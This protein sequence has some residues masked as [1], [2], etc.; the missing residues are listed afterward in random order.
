MEIKAVDGK[1]SVVTLFGP[2]AVGYGIGAAVIFL[3][4]FLFMGLLIAFTPEFSS[5]NSGGPLIMLPM[6]IMV[7]IIVV[8]Q[9][10]MAAGFVILGLAIYRRWGTVRVVSVKEIVES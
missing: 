3:P 5:Q 9:G 7:P 6:I 8:M 1:L 10:V 2:V 4:M